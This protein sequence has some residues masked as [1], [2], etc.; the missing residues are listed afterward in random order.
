MARLV[1]CRGGERRALTTPLLRMLLYPT[2]KKNLL[3]LECWR[4]ERMELMRD[5]DVLGGVGGLY[6]TGN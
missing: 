4:G 2:K 5:D 6:E 1:P 3:T